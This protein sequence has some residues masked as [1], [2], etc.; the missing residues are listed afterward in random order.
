VLADLGYFAF[1]WFDDLTD[2]R[3]WYVSRLRLTTSDAVPHTSYR[4]GETF[5]GVV[6]LGAYRA[7]RAKHAVRLVQFRHGGTR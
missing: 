2:R 4:D 3:S 5:D 1:P 6:W 7:D